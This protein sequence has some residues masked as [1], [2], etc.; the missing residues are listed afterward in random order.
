MVKRKAQTN[1]TKSDENQQAEEGLSAAETIIDAQL[2]ADSPIAG[3]F[4][5]AEIMSCIAALLSLIAVGLALWPVLTTKLANERQAELSAR[6]DA[7]SSALESLVTAQTQLAKTVVEQRGLSGALKTDIEK[8]TAQASE[9]AE[10]LAVNLRAELE[11]LAQKVQETQKEVL[12]SLNLRTLSAEKTEKADD[13]ANIIDN[14]AKRPAN[15]NGADSAPDSQLNSQPLAADEAWVPKWL[16]A[17]MEPVADWFSGLVTIRKTED[18]PE[19]ASQST[20]SSSE[21]T[22]Q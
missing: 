17:A 13:S 16:G 9:Q 10:T 4:S 14:S 18:A 5:R 7:I 21:S 22:S 8:L 20:Q 2:Q 19:A 12:E 6:V 15:P 1:K 3:K 11:S